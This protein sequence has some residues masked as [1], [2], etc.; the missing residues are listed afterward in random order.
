MRK[1]ML[2]CFTLV[3]LVFVF[4]PCLA[5]AQPRL[6]HPPQLL[7]PENGSVIDSQNPE[8]FWTAGSAA[9]GARISYQL[10]IVEMESENQPPADLSSMTPFYQIQMRKTGFAYNG[11]PF[12]SKSV[13]AWQVRIVDADGKPLGGGAGASS[14]FTF[15]CL[16]RDSIPDPTR[17]NLV[18]DTRPLIMTGMRVESIAIST[19]PIVMTGNRVE[20]ITI[21]TEPITMTGF[22]ETNESMPI[23]GHQ[24]PVNVIS[25]AGSNQPPV[26]QPEGARKKIQGVGNTSDAA[27]HNT[28]PGGTPGLTTPGGKIES[29]HDNLSPPQQ[30]TGT[31]KPPPSQVKDK[32]DSGL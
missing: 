24:A 30:Q 9:A 25:T 21:E 13:Y 28:L 31:Q 18:I 7:A 12:S 4:L 10:I 16:M 5:R 17:G 22:R 3:V 6:I 19:R 15:S 8:F 32:S 29:G 20:S 2:S 1:N 11:P 26:Q 14:V 27:H 23:N